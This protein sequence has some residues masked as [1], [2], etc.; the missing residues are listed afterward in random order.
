MWYGG[1]VLKGRGREGRRNK[2]KIILLT[3]LFYYIVKETGND[4]WRQL[5]SNF[6]ESHTKSMKSQLCLGECQQSRAGPNFSLCPGG[7]TLA[8]DIMSLA[9]WSSPG[10]PPRLNTIGTLFVLKP[11]SVLLQEPS[12]LL[13][14]W[15]HPDSHRRNPKSIQILISPTL[16]LNVETWRPQDWEWLTQNWDPHFLTLKSSSFPPIPQ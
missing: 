7:Y 13:W 16:V 2:I 11:S 1:L 6:E 14:V 5:F 10:P 12:Y 15:N 9:L 4:K 3:P 8:Y